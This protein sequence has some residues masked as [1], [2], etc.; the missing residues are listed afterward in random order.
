MN[1]HGAVLG[2]EPRETAGLNVR[3]GPSK[4]EAHGAHQP[5]KLSEGWLQ[6]RRPS[7][8]LSQQ[9]NCP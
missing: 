3:P 8:C 7:S 2:G 6:S 9:R 1:S 4:N 5:A